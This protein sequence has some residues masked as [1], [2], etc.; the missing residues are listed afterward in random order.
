MGSLGAA[1]DPEGD[2]PGT[3][4]ALAWCPP[5]R[6]QVLPLPLNT[7]TLLRAELCPSEAPDKR[8]SG[9]RAGSPGG[10]H[11]GQ[12]VAGRA[13]R[14][15]SP[16]TPD[17]P[18]AERSGVAPGSPVRED[19]GRSGRCLGRRKED[20]RRMWGPRDGSEEEADAA[21]PASCAPRLGGGTGAED[22]PAARA[23]GQHAVNVTRVVM[24]IPKKDEARDRAKEACLT[25]ESAAQRRPTGC[26]RTPSSEG[27]T[28]RN[29]NPGRITVTR[30]RDSK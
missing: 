7:Q 10:A 26:P 11:W 2:G 30:R 8:G 25:H 3:R 24:R 14:G 23:R 5:S 22:S 1:L 17:P 4:R 27:R 13:A 20:P 28:E 15:L 16:G 18:S 12:R 19:L 9:Q 29:L 21:S 6:V